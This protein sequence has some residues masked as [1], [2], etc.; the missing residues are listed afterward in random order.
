MRFA[1]VGNSVNKT[2][3]VYAVGK[4]VEFVGDMQK[5]LAALHA[6]HFFGRTPKQCRSLPVLF[7]AGLIIDHVRQRTGAA[8]IRK[9]LSAARPARFP[10]GPPARSTSQGEQAAVEA[11]NGIPECSLFAGS[12][13]NAR[14]P[15]GSEGG[16]GQRSSATGGG[17]LDQHANFVVGK[18]QMRH[19]A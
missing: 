10:P 12:G 8:S 16:I 4:F 19:F 3:P 9:A 14:N 6:I 18:C 17:V 2:R 7:R 5:E 13:A 1:R 11:L 15:G